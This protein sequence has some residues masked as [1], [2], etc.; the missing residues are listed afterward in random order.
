MRIGANCRADEASRAVP[1]VVPPMPISW[2]DIFALTILFGTLILALA[3]S[4][5]ELS[6]TA[7]AVLVAVS[8]NALYLPRIYVAYCSKRPPGFRPP[9]EIVVGMSATGII[10]WFGNAFL[11]MTAGTAFLASGGLGAIAL[12]YVAWAGRHY[13][14]ELNRPRHSVRNLSRKHRMELGGY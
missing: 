1:K 14:V 7:I 8:V 5:E 2:S 3:I 13:R 9:A 6:L 10:I 12:A 4:A 11:G